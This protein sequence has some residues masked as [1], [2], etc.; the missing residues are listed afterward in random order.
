MTSV[1]GTT[2]NNPYHRSMVNKVKITLTCGCVVVGNNRPMRRTTT[3][4][5]PSNL[6]HGYNVGWARWEDGEHS[7]TPDRSR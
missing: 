7:G 5:C 4:S 2:G 3:Y 1:T 6:G